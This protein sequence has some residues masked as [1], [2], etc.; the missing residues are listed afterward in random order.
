M[1]SKVAELFKLSI[2][3]ET[4][5]DILGGFGVRSRLQRPTDPADLIHLLQKLHILRLEAGVIGAHV[6]FWESLDN[7]SK[8]ENPPFKR[9]VHKYCDVTKDLFYS[10]G[11]LTTKS[12]WDRRIEFFLV[13]A[14][15]AQTPP[16]LRFLILH[17]PPVL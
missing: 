2:M 1:M 9:K 13:E 5:A 8:K 15:R 3:A 10:M 11:N 4:L 7:P 16:V 12:I 14:A 17:T 6:L